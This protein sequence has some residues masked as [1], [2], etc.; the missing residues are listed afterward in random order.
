MPFTDWL[1]FLEELSI[2]KGGTSG[3]LGIEKE[4]KVLE[5]QELTFA[6]VICYES[7]YGEFNAKQCRK[8]AQAIFIITN[9]GWWQD[10]PGYKQHMSFS[11]LRAIENRRSVARSANTGISCFI[12][13]RG[14]V[15]KRSKWWE[16]IALKGTINLN[17]DITT[18][19]KYGD[20]IGRSFAFVS[21]L[22]LLLTFTRAFK[23]IF[24]R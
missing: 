12:N 9:D 2:D 18:Y 21:A 22:I 17:N 6:P 11:R 1:P 7:I 24:T 16:P 14:D 4:V 10:T 8:G 13:Q 20:V 23:R 3:S 15:V 19:T 5:T